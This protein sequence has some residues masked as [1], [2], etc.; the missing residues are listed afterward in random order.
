MRWPGLPLVAEW[1]KGLRSVEFFKRWE[2]AH[3]P[4]RPGP[5]REG[6]LRAHLSDSAPHVARVKVMAIGTMA[7]VAG[8]A[9]GGASPGSA[10]AGSVGVVRKNSCGS[11]AV[12]G[13]TLGPRVG[14]PGEASTA[15][16]G[17][18]SGG[19]RPPRD[20]GGVELLDLPHHRGC[21]EPSVPEC[22]LGLAHSRGPLGVVQ[23]R[24]QRRGERVG[25][26][27]GRGVL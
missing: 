6:P 20:Q 25:S 17:R 22:S 14:A 11:P 19:K 5:R 2:A 8:S 1:A 12:P 7:E 23:D 13:S 4:G 26:P 9:V 10:P 15:E 16:R 27:G 24:R 18:T 21:S 3:D